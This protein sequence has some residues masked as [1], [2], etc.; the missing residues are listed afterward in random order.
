VVDAAGQSNAT[1]AER[2]LAQMI[3]CSPSGTADVSS[4]SPKLAPVVQRDGDD[5]IFFAFGS[6]ML[7]LNPDA[8]PDGT[9]GS[10]GRSSIDN[11]GLHVHQV[12]IL[13]DGRILTFSLLADGSSYRVVRRLPNGSPD[14]DFGDG[15]VLA[16]MTLPFKP[17]WTGGSSMFYWYEPN[18]RGFPAIDRH[19]RVL[20][21]GSGADPA[22]GIQVSYLARFDAGMNLDVSFGS[23]GTGVVALGDPALGRFV[24]VTAAID[25]IDRIVL[26][27][28]LSRED[29]PPPY[30]TRYA[31]AV[32]RLNATPLRCPSP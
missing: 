32:T 14:P 17:F 21:A 20:I 1:L 22:S 8:T 12:L 29:L 13:G 3:R 6:C 4:V 23:A 7:K 31:E 19:G 9:F 28:L 2:F 26:G 24:P 5:R 10:D 18:T 27:G 30:R 25:D 15:G 16:A 11:A